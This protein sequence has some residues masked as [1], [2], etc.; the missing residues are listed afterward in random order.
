MRKRI[1]VCAIFFAVLTIIGNA[2]VEA[3]N[4]RSAMNPIKIDG[5]PGEV[6]NSSFQMTL[7]K[8]EKRTF[9]K[10][11]IEDWWRSEDGKQSFYV[12]PGT[13]GTPKRSCAK[14]VKINP[15]ETSVD[16]AGM[17]DVRVTVSIPNDVKPGGYWCALTVD[18]V[19]DPLAI[20]GNVGMRFLASVSIGIY[21][22]IT[23]LDR[24][25]RI[26]DVQIQK[27]LATVKLR[28]DGNTP[29]SVEGRFEFIKPGETK[30]KATIQIPKGTLLPE[31]VNTGVYTSK[32]PSASDLP[33]GKYLV[34][35]IMDI[36]LDHYIGVQKEM[37]IQHDTV[38]TAQTK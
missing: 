9:F 17:L 38:Q 5:R 36:G 12:E 33:S 28:N 13:P 20:Q 2:P 30:P 27:E 25:A 1:V 10:A 23:P 26:L 22:Y 19:P 8:E 29:L 35:A 18:E 34:R 3:L 14:W 16:P 32:L 37:E 21:V 15:V 24:T 4:F 11:H 7:G 6:A 31:P